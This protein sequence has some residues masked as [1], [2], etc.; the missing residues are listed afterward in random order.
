[1]PN[2]AKKAKEL[3]DKLAEE[4]KEW[5]GQVGTTAYK[6]KQAREAQAKKLKEIMGG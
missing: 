5:G 6:L 2:N 4:G 1:M 3:T